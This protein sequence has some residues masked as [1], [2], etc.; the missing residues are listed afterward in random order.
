M[1]DIGYDQ[2]LR[3]IKNMIVPVPN[4]MT[5]NELTQWLN[6]YRAAIYDITGLVE[7]LKKGNEQ[8]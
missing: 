8:G 3:G 1:T 6:G 5:A 4:N 7:D 2:I